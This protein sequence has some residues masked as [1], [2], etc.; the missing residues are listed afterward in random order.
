MQRMISHPDPLAPC[1]K[2]HTARHIHDL[3]RPSAGGGHC[4][5]C[6]CS[7]TAPH[8]DFEHALAE[9]ELMH[10]KPVAKRT[11]TA[12]RQVFPTMP[13]LHLAL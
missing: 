9:W 5:E 7:H 4:I 3:R 13:Q 11:R 6:A 8:E 2:G 1:S 12:P 10:R